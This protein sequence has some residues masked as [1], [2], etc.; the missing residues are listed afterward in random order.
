[1]LR[2]HESYVASCSTLYLS[3]MVLSIIMCPLFRD[4]LKWTVSFRLPS[5]KFHLN[6]TFQG[7]SSD[8]LFSMWCRM[9]MRMRCFS[10]LSS[11]QILSLQFHLMRWRMGLHIHFLQGKV[12]WDCFSGF[13][14]F[15]HNVHYCRGFLSACYFCTYTYFHGALNIYE[16][17]ECNI[18]PKPH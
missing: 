18:E 11:V 9:K 14:L 6:N 10:E 2:L 5:S 16:F 1:M 13:N 12:T 7:F 4:C 17:E 8:C 3:L 15:L